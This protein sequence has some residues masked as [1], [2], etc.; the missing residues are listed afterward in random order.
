MIHFEIVL[1]LCEDYS[2]AMK[3]V[4][5][6]AIVYILF[7]LTLPCQDAFAAHRET[8]TG[9][10]TAIDRIDPCEEEPEV[11]SPFCICS[12]CGLPALYYADLVAASPKCKDIDPH[13]MQIEFR[14]LAPKAFPGSV[15]QPPKH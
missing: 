7:L 1:C 11:C 12:C 5:F 10:T 15:W 3:A 2:G 13:Q 8:S 4:S 6:F 14:S 9:E